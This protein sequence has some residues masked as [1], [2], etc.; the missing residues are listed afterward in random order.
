M[1]TK[2]ALWHCYRCGAESDELPRP[3]YCTC[4]AAMGANWSML[5]VLRPPPPATTT[6]RRRT[7]AD[8]PS[9]R[10]IAQRNYYK[11]RQF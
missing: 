9:M 10:R 5:D 1:T 8:T 11:G 7:A 4:G 3:R 2:K 6:G